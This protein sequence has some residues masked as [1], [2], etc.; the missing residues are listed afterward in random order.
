[1]KKIILM[2]LS[3]QSFCVEATLPDCGKVAAHEFSVPE[4]V[5][6]AL[7]LEEKDSPKDL[8]RDLYGPM[9]LGEFLIP[10]AAQGIKTTETKVKTDICENYRAAAWLLTKPIRDG[11]TSDIWIAVNHYYYGAATRSSYPVTDR[12]K[13]RTKDL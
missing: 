8:N 9:G 3:L 5:F 1:M 12:V 2:V 4:K 11:L 10:L 13:S 7:A 6:L